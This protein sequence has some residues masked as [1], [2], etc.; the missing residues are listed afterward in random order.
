MRPG[1]LRSQPRPGAG[2]QQREAV[3]EAPGP[4]LARLERADQRVAVTFSV[5]ATSGE[6]SGSRDIQMITAKRANLIDA[7]F[8]GYAGLADHASSDGPG[9]IRTIVLT[10]MSRLL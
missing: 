1:R 3:D 7:R 6:C 10:I 8:P 4:L 9:W 2:D 5:T